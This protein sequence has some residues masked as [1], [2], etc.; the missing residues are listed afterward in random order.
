MTRPEVAATSDHPAVPV[1]LLPGLPSLAR[2][3]EPLPSAPQGRRLPVALFRL[4]RGENCLIAAGCTLAGAHLISSMHAVDQSILIASCISVA[5]I[6]GFG[7]VVNDLF[8]IE[9]DRIAKPHRVLPS[10]DLTVNAAKLWAGTLLLGAIA[11]S[12]FLAGPLQV[13]VLAMA[14]LGFTYSWKLKATPPYG[15]LVVA[16]QTCLTLV[17]GAVAQGQAN[18]KVLLGSILL[19]FGMLTIE[20]AKTIED[21]H[22][23]RL[24]NIHTIAHVIPQR[25][26]STVMRGTVALCASICLVPVAMGD[27]VTR[28]VALLF[29]APLVPLAVMLRG[30]TEPDTYRLGLAIRLSKIVWVGVVVGLL[31]L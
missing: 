11:A 8:D 9:V 3:G 30:S 15:N 5:L 1:T 10:E 6:L 14:L 7:N 22:G 23:D 19:F 12:F 20:V 4:A 18:G 17:F 2:E 27:G 25:A 21:Q 13:F 24:A 28:V 26:H 29:L 31:S 16:L